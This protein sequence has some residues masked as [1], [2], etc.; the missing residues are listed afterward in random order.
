[1]GL[2]Q[3]IIKGSL[4]NGI[5][6]FGVQF[7]NIFLT[8]I[9]ARKLD[10]SDF[11][12]LGMVSVVIGILGYFSEFGL[13]ASLI[14]EEHISDLDCNTAFWAGIG[15]SIMVYII[16]YLGAPLLAWFYGID[17]LI[18]IA[19]I[20]GLVFIISSYGFVPCALEM[21]QLKYNNLAI[22]TLLSCIISGIVATLMAFRGFGVWTLVWQQII[23]Q[24]SATL[25]YIIMIKW[26]P[27]FIFSIDRL[28]V[29]LNYG[30]HVT[31]NNILKFISENIDYLLVGKLLG[32]SSLGIYTM[33][34]R[35]SR[36]PIEKAMPIFGR[37]LFPAFASIQNNPIRLKTNFFRISAM[38]PFILTPFIITLFFITKSVIIV[39]IGE[40]WLESAILIKF[41]LFYILFLSFSF[42]DESILMLHNIKLLNLLKLIISLAFV[43]VGYFAFSLYGLNEGAC[44]YTIMFSL[45]YIMLK[46]LVLKTLKISLISYLYCN[47]KVIAYILILMVIG[48]M[49]NHFIVGSPL[50][51]VIT[52]VGIQI[53]SM[54]TILL[55]L[56]I[57]L[58]KPFSINI[59]RCTSDLKSITS[60]IG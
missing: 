34:F 29:I 5:A 11:G 53:T 31:A 21:K 8:I 38:L 18:T 3:K 46:L 58:L 35:L 40:K 42:S 27:K 44:V 6:Q 1:M 56:K 17:E 37:M 48:F 33:A 13:I 51:V 52:F 30:T 2:K 19:R 41:F 24:L 36:Y 43:I 22:I 10:P 49:V 59:D 12:L 47:R 32:S 20:L 14:K 4:W 7:V 50:F 57:I 23:M 25:G 16:I 55:H 39:T 60:L 45:Y 9:L 54:L 26:H 15:M 28:K